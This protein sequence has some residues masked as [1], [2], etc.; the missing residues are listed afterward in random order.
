MGAG[1]IG[2]IHTPCLRLVIPTCGFDSARRL[3]VWPSW[4]WLVSSLGRGACLVRPWSAGLLDLLS[5]TVSRCRVAL[6]DLS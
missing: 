3:S 4:R 6:A 5:L 1:V 2:L